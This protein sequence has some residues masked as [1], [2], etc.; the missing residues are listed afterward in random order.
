MTI[1][2]QVITDIMESVAGVFDACKPLILLLFGVGIVF[3]IARNIQTLLP[4][5]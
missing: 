1:S 4:K 3:F 2:T 5:K